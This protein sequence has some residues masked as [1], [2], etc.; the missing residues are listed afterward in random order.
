[1]TLLPVLFGHEQVAALILRVVL[2][3]T[4][5]YF[6]WQKIQAKGDGSGSNSVIYGY[7]ELLIAAFL[8][9]GF[10]T[11]EAVLINIFILLIKI[12]FKTKEGK[13]FSHGVNYYVL[14]LAMA[15]A[16]L[17]TGPGMWAVD[18]WV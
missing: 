2:G 17:L 6:A 15:V 13:L 7:I 9:V 3:L 16:L 4:L 14:L 11:Q 18:G 10:F 1:M 12:G 8:I 5:A